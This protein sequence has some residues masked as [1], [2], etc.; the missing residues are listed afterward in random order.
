MPNT[1]QKLHK[2]HIKYRNGPVDLEQYFVMLNSSN[3]SY[4]TYK[5]SLTTAQPGRNML[6][7]Q[8]ICRFSPVF[9]VYC[10][11]STLNDTE[12]SHISIKF[13]G[14]IDKRRYVY[15]RIHQHLLQVN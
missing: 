8:S 1:K 14:H 11:M 3:F 15:T 5:F 10:C 12:V 13:S 2:F 7:E 6:K 9:A 4:V